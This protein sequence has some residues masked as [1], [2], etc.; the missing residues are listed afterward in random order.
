VNT[1]GLGTAARNAEA[2]RGPRH[3]PDYIIER[4]KAVPD[5]GRAPSATAELA[6]RIESMR[7]I[8]R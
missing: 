1:R 6:A 7:D 4:L 5:A 2:S 8:S 3:A